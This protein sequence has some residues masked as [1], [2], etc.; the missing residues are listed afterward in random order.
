MGSSNLTFLQT[1]SLIMKFMGLIFLAL[2]ALCLMTTTSA[3]A[4][5]GI[6][7]TAAFT[8][9]GGLVLT[10]ANATPVWAI[11]R[12]A[13]TSRHAHNPQDK[14]SKKP[15]PPADVTGRGESD[16]CPGSLSS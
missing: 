16:A 14:G 6:V 13:R 15:Y 4:P 5:F 7:E 3:P 11:V 8:T 1:S 10:T 12:R 2:S 9:A